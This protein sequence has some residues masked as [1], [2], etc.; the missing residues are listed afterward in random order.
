MVKLK[1]L[2][3]AAAIWGLTSALAGCGGNDGNDAGTAGTGG[4]SNQSLAPV[5][6]KVVVPG[7]KGA[8]FD[9]VMSEVNKRLKADL[10]TQVDFTFIDFGD[11]NQKTNVMLASGE[12]VD[13][14]FDAPWLHLD[15]MS[16]Q[17]FYEELTDLLNQYGSHVRET[18]PQQ[19]WDANKINGKIYGVPL[20]SAYTQPRS[21]FIRK[22]LREKLNLPP[23]RTYE[24]LKA[25]L[26]AVHDREPGITPL[27]AGAD[28]VT[29]SWVNWLVRDDTS[30]GVRPTNGIGASLMLYYKG[31]DGK[32]YNLF[33]AQEPKIWTYIEDTRKLFMDK[34][35]SQDVMTNKS[36]QSDMQL[37]NKVAATPQMAFGIP[38]SFNDR[39][40]QVVPDGELEAVRLFDLKLGSNLSNYKMDNFICIVKASK[41]K[42]R[43]MMF[44]DW[45]NQKDNYDLLERGIEGKNW[46]AVGDHRYET[47]NSDGG[48]VSFQLMLNPVLEREWAGTDEE[49]RKYN[50]F[51][52]QADHFTKDIMTGFTFDPTPVKNEVAQ[53]STIQA[54]Y[55]NGL[56]NGALDPD[57]YFAKFKAEGE[58]PLKKIQN[59]LQKQVDA[60]L[61]K[62][63]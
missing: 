46:K 22:D 2:L 16:S 13:L 52:A 10:N 26:Y 62:Q 5:T 36:S 20:G 63:S 21:V 4:Q 18:R 58:A 33:D 59:E 11:L 9:E 32:V 37:Q 27:I 34:V 56:F 25:Y 43:A 29:Y 54:K 30:L 47:L 50:Q 42:D 44:L 38:Q 49:T 12:N 53:F 61:G 45:A 35:M 6:L 57:E 31:N 51:I 28:D 39:L 48:I 19:M 1:S 55:Y 60:F 3:M 41:H 8:N 7:G 24:D 40:K 17:G 14:I 23:V 15:S